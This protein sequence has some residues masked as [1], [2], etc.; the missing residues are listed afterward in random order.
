MTRRGL[1]EAQ[2]PFIHDSSPRTLRRVKDF[3]PRQR[4]RVEARVLQTLIERADMAEDVRAFDAAKAADGTLIP[5]AV[6]DRIWDGANR[7]MALREWR[8]LKQGELAAT[9]GL[10]QAYVCEIEK[11]KNISARAAKSL[12]KALGVDVGDLL[13]DV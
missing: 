9:A 8:G 10:S 1:A 5:G 4:L 6:M 7:V 3:A 11:G 12:A 13:T 2:E